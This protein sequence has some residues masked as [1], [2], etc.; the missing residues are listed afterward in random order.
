MSK[1]VY[2]SPEQVAARLGFSPRT[3]I[4]RAKPR[5]GQ[6]GDFG[7]G[8]LFV[9]F[10]AA[11]VRP[12]AS[13]A[14]GKARPVVRAGVWRIPADAVEAFEQRCRVFRPLGGDSAA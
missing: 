13:Q 10:P 5:D 12:R 9:P 1:V 14:T 2:L 8:V 4:E 6:P 3:I 11:P 7:A